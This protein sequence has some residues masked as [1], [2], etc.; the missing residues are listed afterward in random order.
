MAQPRD[1]D[2][3]PAQ[4]NSNGSEPSSDTHYGSSSFNG[5]V[6]PR[7]SRVHRDDLKDLRIGTPKFDRSLK[8]KDYLEWVQSMEGIIEIKGYSGEKAFKLIVLKL[9]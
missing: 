2:R 1:R 5:D 6:R 4:D 3:E 9:K 8:P 7:R